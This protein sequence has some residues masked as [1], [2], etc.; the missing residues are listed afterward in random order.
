MRWLPGRGGARPARLGRQARQDLGIPSRERVLG[1]GIALR[2]DG[3]RIPEV[4]TDQA[5]SGT[6]LGSRVGWEAIDKAAWDDPIMVLTASLDGA[7]RREE[8]DLIEQGQLP[9]AIRTQVTGSVVISE[10]LDLGAGVGVQ[11][12]ARRSSL[13]GRI[14]WSLTFDPGVDP[15]DALRVRAEAALAG[16]RSTLGI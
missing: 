3:A 7:V 6:P 16:L 1:W 15:D 12:I 8:L 11:A 2:P 10:R 14:R 13:D 9:A 5:L 4:A